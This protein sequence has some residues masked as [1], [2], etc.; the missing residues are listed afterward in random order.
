M[1]K[2][3]VNVKTYMIH[4]KFLRQLINC[5]L[6][7][8]AFDLSVLITGVEKINLTPGRN[9]RIKSRNS[10]NSL[11]IYSGVRKGASLVP[12]CSI[13]RSGCFISNGTE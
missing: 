5:L 6:F 2:D 12:V 8:L 3:L 7:S 4:S 11:N 9:L 1:L 10:F 13:I